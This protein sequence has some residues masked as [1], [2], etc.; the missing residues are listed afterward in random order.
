VSGR[1]VEPLVERSEQTRLGRGFYQNRRLQPAAIRDTARAVAGFAAEARESGAVATRVIATSA[2]RDAVNQ[3]ELIAAIQTA[4]GLAVEIISGEQE[5]DWTFRGVNS[6]TVF[7]GHP[8]LIVDV[9]GGS[10]E[11]ILGEGDHQRFRHSFPL[12]T[13]R[14]MEQWPR[15]D[16]PGRT[17]W[18][19][20]RDR[21]D[22]FLDGHVRPAVESEL[23]TFSERAVQ[24]VGTGGTS[25][26]LARVEL[27]LATFDRDRIEALRLTLDQ[28]RRQRER[29]WSLPLAERKKIAGL[30]PDRADVILTGVP[31]Y[32]LLMEKF[33]F[34]DLR[35]STR[36]LRFAAVM[37][38]PG[39]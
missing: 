25:S 29:L 14:L 37:E 13:V 21:V 3:H 15:S 18:E 17:D 28:V 27:G 16:P 1:R 20:C 9:G 6:D 4:S 30:P 34:P 23:G 24:L 8:L 5:A 22:S 35:V 33:A 7:A 26:I 10:T 12:G 32:E 19:E 39:G 36:G 2:A 38:E 31:I 11:F